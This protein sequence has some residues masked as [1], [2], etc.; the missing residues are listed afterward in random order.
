MSALV[1]HPSEVSEVPSQGEED[2]DSGRPSVALANHTLPILLDR[3]K[4]ILTET[5][6]WIYSQSEELM[7]VI[8][9]VENPH[10]HEFRKPLGECLGAGRALG[11][12]LEQERSNASD[13]KLVGDTFDAYVKDLERLVREVPL[14]LRSHSAVFGSFRPGAD[15]KLL[16]ETYRLENTLR[17]VSPTI[18]LFALSIQAGAYR[19]GNPRDGFKQVREQPISAKE[20]FTSSDTSGPLRSLPST[21]NG[22]THK[23]TSF[24]DSHVNTEGLRG[25]A[26]QPGFSVGYLENLACHPS[27]PYQDMPEAYARRRGHDKRY[28]SEGSAMWPIH[29]QKSQD[30]IGNSKPT[31]LTLISPKHQRAIDL[32]RIWMSV[33]P[34]PLTHGVLSQYFIDVYNN[35]ERSIGRE[36]GPVSDEPALREDVKGLSF[37]A[38]LE[39][40]EPFVAVDRGSGL[41][42]FTSADAEI[43][44]AQHISK[45]VKCEVV[46]AVVMA[47]L[48][49]LDAIEDFEQGHCP[50][51]EELVQ[52]LKT[53]PF[54][55]QLGSLG[56]YV[57]L[58]P[59]YD[60]S[61]GERVR[62]KIIDLLNSPKRLLLLQVFFYTRENDLNEDQSLSW[63][64][65]VLSIK[66][67]SKLH[68]AALWGESRIVEAYL[69]E[70]RKSAEL[71]SLCGSRP[72][73][74]AAKFGG[75]RVVQAMLNA[76]PTMARA[77]DNNGKTPLFYASHGADAEAFIL[78]FE[79]Q[80][81]GTTLEEL[82]E[83]S[84]QDL[85]DALKKYCLEKTGLEESMN[86]DRYMEVAMLQA[87]R[88]GLDV[89]AEL[90]L[91]RGANPNVM[92]HD[93][94]A[95][96]IAAQQG[97][98][99]LV[100]ML[101]SKGAEAIV[102]I[103]EGKESV[104]HV[105]VK[106]RMKQSL[107]HLIE[108]WKKIDINCKDAKGRTALFSAVELGD[109]DWAMEAMEAMELLLWRGLNIDLLDTDGNHIMHIV[110]D[111]G[112][113][114]MYKEP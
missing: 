56:S 97:K 57:A 87:I 31:S 46:I 64:K 55:Y 23:R 109:E 94:S 88:E 68:I 14:Q 106:K 30:W 34:V 101:L 25:E 111:K 80:C 43:I 91:S 19:G 41:V 114:T 85:H 4:S 11:R 37:N 44:A 50:T 66:S 100:T 10:I 62:D 98:D 81:A 104:L 75:I 102:G 48:A 6:T 65:L 9:D 90:L 83:V 78:L 67:T 28:L 70:D 32:L 60:S 53:H 99:H 20:G 35:W 49:C 42:Y 103:P 45:R 8:R 93:E 52:L 15:D 18:E 95:L 82:G 21:P 38:V 63:D 22:I 72:L 29:S 39:W 40:W 2:A 108:N 69:K 27:R 26:A 76:A 61:G 89:V 24:S 71:K 3:I 47:F 92:D 13:F 79:A 54:L 33:S 16:Q 58:I 96:Y 107:K 112:Y 36:T 105:L 113:T 17:E 59:D 77:V 74:E 73:H 1:P 12:L 5:H 110:A 86:E 84:R 7:E 51:E